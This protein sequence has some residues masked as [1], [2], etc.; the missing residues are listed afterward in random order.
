[1]SRCC[2]RSPRCAR[3]RRSRL[4]CASSEGDVIEPPQDVA[5]G[6]REPIEDVARN[7]ERWVSAAVVRTFAQARIEEFADAAPRLRVVNALTNEEHP[8]QALADMPDADRTLGQPAGP[9]DRLR[10]RRQQRRDL[11][12]AGGNHARRSR[13]RRVPLRLRTAAA[14]AGPHCRHGPLGRDARAHVRSGC[15]RS[16]RR[17]RLHRRMDVDGP[18]K[19]GGRPARRLRVHI[20]STPP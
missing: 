13:P 12:R 11:A 16:R 6:G 10:R 4:P 2:S 1:M 17:R 5:L 20:R 9:H 3:A 19:R 18:G 14:G 15:R 7:L 8:C